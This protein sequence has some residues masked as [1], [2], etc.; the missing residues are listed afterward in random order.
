M[1]S[2]A[3]F[4]NEF[5]EFFAMLVLTLLMFA[6]VCLCLCLAEGWF[7]PNH[8]PISISPCILGWFV[9]LTFVKLSFVTG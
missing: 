2:R 7:E 9:K 3:M 4:T 6:Y 5:K 1:I 8:L